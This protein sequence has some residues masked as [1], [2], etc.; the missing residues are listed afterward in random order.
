[1]R[2]AGVLASASKWPPLIVPK[3]DQDGEAAGA[4]CNDHDPAI[5]LHAAEVFC[6]GI[7]QDCNGSDCCANDED[8]DGAPCSAD[9]DDKDPNTFPGAPVPSGC[10]WK[11]VN[12]D[13]TLDGVCH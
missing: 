6:D 2:Y 5:S 12:C 10:Y 11:D 1:V 8:G 13:G 3:P 9:C 4:D 7:D